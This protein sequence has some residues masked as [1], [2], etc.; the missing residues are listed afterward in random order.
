[1]TNLFNQTKLIVAM[2][3]LALV[4]LV[5]PACSSDA[6]SDT[7]DSLPGSFD[8][9]TKELARGSLTQGS[10]GLHVT[11]SGKVTIDPDIA[12][13]SMGVEG[14]ALTVAEARQIAADALA[15]MLDSLQTNG[16]PQDDVRTTFFNIQP[17]YEWR[18]I[19][20]KGL[21]KSERVLSGYR[22]TNSLTITVRDLDGVGDVIDGL[23][24]GG[25]DATRIKGIG[26]DIEDRAA[27]QAQAR[28]LALRDAVT[29]ADMFASETGVSRGKLVFV[30]ETS[31]AAPQSRAFAL[32]SAA[33]ADAFAGAP[34]AIVAGDLDVIVT[35]S[36]V[37][38]I[39]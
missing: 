37:F 2:A 35:V 28:L 15:G 24:T 33:T 22:V 4:A 1:V 9:L 27:V 23:A 16:V 32:Q 18:E 26:F 20:E 31:F 39:D 13:I 11:G 3:A 25:G 12:T 29:K 21:R 7:S 34:T 5:A 30:T 8:A 38:G 17:E 36:A 10:T 14:F 6:P 19:T